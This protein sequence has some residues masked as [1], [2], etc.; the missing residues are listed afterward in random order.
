MAGP[1]V[2]LGE[3]MREVG[4]DLDSG[5]PREGVE[6]LTRLLMDLEIGQGIGAGRERDPDLH[7]PPPRAWEPHLLHE[8]DGNA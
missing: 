2:T 1:I 5:F 4:S 6:S 7:D 8:P 3:Y